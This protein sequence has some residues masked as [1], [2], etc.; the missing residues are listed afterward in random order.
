MRRH[1][2]APATSFGSASGRFALPWRRPRPP[3][4]LRS[5]HRVLARPRRPVSL[6]ALLGGLTSADPASDTPAPRALPDD[7]DPL[8]DFFDERPRT[9]PPPLAPPRDRG[10]TQGDH[11]QPQ[12]ESF[13]LPPVGSP[14]VTPPAPAPA[15][16]PPP[17]APDG[18]LRAFLEGAGL[19]PNDVPTADAEALMRDAG[20]IFAAMAEGLR[21]LLAARAMVKTHAGL[22][23]TVIGAAGNNPLKYS[24]APREAVTALLRQREQ[25]YLAPLPAVEETFRDLKAHELALLDGM[26]AA[27]ASLLGRFDPKVLESA[28]ADASTLSV[29]LQGGRRARLWELYTERYAELAEAARLRFLGDLDRAFADA[30]E[31]K[32]REH[33]A[34]RTS[35]TGAG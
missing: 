31:D 28:L 1:R 23:R 14:S 4:R 24:V 5:A 15:M 20:R 13:G 32:V 16:E 12:L 26:R 18:A 9:P 29:L 33:P 17:T 34:S 10:T 8:G 27:V 22:E 3:A 25:G 7:G 21:Q 11:G 19:A 30:Y 2:S 6:D 35:G